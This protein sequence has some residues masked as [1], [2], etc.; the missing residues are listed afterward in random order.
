[1]NLLETFRD[2]EATTKVFP[3]KL[4]NYKELCKLLSIKE[5]SNPESRRTQLEDLQQYCELR[6]N[7]RI[8]YI[9]KIFSEPNIILKFDPKANFQ[10]LLVKNLLDYLY[11]QE[12]DS[13]E[14]G[15]VRVKYLTRGDLATNLGLCKDIFYSQKLFTS[16]DYSLKLKSLIESGEILQDKTNQMKHFVEQFF[17]LN[18]K[19]FYEMLSSMVGY[20]QK[21]NLFIV[22][23]RFQQMIDGCWQCTTKEDDLR[24]MEI[25]AKL[26]DNYG[27]S[28]IQVAELMYRIGSS[29]ALDTELDNFV[30]NYMEQFQLSYFHR[31]VYELSYTKEILRIL[32][33]KNH[34]DYSSLKEEVLK[35]QLELH[36]LAFKA[37]HTGNDTE[38]KSRI[39][40]EVLVREC[41]L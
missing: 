9:D 25:R 3:I 11:L 23:P 12:E 29:G 18:H 10:A 4:S 7:G 30:I 24:L 41:I 40:W 26:L 5:Q 17:K 6:N 15:S 16:K 31:G 22:V 2:L 13:E 35:K 8:F 39:A 33:K 19:A 20:I 21:K 32:V 36:K 37:I 1:M 27:L 38:E 14:L 28:A 34:A